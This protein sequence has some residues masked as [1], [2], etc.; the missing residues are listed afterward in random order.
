MEP[1]K[2]IDEIDNIT[3]RYKQAFGNLSNEQLNWKPNEKTWSI[4]QIMDHI[5]V[6]NETYYPIFD[7]LRQ[8][9]YKASFM[10]R[11]GF[12]VNLFGNLILK[13]VQPDSR[14]KVKTFPIWEPANSEIKGD[15]LKRFEDH[16][17]G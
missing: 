7:A 10:S 11:F 6:L 14:K 9:R 13:S 5:V 4:A 17:T 2:W 15:I 12:M 1:D 16:Q 3:G 8:G